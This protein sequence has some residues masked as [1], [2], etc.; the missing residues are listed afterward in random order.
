MLR[1]WFGKQE[2]SPFAPEP[3]EFAELNFDFHPKTVQKWLREIGFHIE[4]MLTVSHFRMGLLKRWVPTGILV[5]LDSLAQWTGSVL[6]VDAQC[7]REGQ[8]RRGE[9]RVYPG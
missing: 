2:W 6:A 5:A 1:Y 9:Q 3:V 8:S 7:F 4:R